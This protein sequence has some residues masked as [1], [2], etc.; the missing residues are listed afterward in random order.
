MNLGCE[1]GA[2]DAGGLRLAPCDVEV[3]ETADGRGHVAPPRGN[4][5]LEIAA[6]LEQ[7]G[8]SLVVAPE[9]DQ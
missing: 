6:C 5:C 3:H 4:G 2:V 9:R 7:H 8:F 1:H